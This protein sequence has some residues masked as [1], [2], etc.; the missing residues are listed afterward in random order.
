[1][2][3][4]QRTPSISA[5]TVPKSAYGGAGASRIGLLGNIDLSLNP[6]AE[7]TTDENLPQYHAETP[8]SLPLVRMSSTATVIL[9]EEQS[10]YTGSILHGYGAQAYDQTNEL[11]QR[12]PRRNFWVWG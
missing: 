10:R 3:K 5:Y 6:E 1:M 12:D 2:S 7:T 4:I 8:V 9:L 11:M